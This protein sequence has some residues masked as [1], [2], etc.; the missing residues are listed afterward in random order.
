MSLKKLLTEKLK[1]TGQNANE[2]AKAAGITPITFKAVL[3]GKSVPNAR[4][5][6]KYAS[7]LGLSTDE[8]A[9][10]AGDRKGKKTASGKKP[11]RP[12]KSA[13]AAKAAG[14]AKKRGR[15]AKA[16]V[17]KSAKAK[18]APTKK[19]GRPAQM[20]APAV[21]TSKKRGRPAKVQFA[22]VGGPK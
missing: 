6:P 9:K 3:A 19:R 21:A 7:F 15:P 13:Q 22:G 12:A 2:A 5:L 18:K 14:V 11:G 16:K 10:I 4:S 20:T 1:A 8:V 17:A